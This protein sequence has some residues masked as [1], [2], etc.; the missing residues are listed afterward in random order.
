M[1][2]VE[3]IPSL[4]VQSADEFKRKVRQVENVCAVGHVD[5]LDGEMFDNATWYDA[6]AASSFETVMDFELHLMVNNPLPI[7][8]QWLAAPIEVVRVIIHAEMKNALGMLPL[9]N[10]IRDLDK[11]VEPGIALNPATPVSTIADFL[12]MVGCVLVMG[13]YPGFSGQAF[14]ADVGHSCLLDKI[15]GL[16][17]HYPHL[18]IEVDGGVNEETIPALVEAGA[19]LLCAASL[20]FNAPDPGLKAVE[21]QEQFPY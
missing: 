6:K 13:V 8:R 14:G 3:I 15:A 19:N 7:I 11:D 1:P 2:Q 17:H 18:N 16:R 9:L 12:P 21:L 10:N 20:I 4:L 5:I